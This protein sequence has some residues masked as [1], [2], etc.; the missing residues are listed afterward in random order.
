MGSVRP[1]TSTTAAFGE[2]TRWMSQAMSTPS[3]PLKVPRCPAS[4]AALSGPA[5]RASSVAS[6][7]NVLGPGRASKSSG[8]ARG[9]VLGAR[10]AARLERRRARSGSLTPA[11]LHTARR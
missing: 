2:G 1:V 3:T 7:L 11:V 9:A 10:Q 5:Q 8:A 4:C 6:A